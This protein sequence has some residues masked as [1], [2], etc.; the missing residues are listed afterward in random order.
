VD[1][2]GDVR[3]VLAEYVRR[4]GF[5]VIEAS[6]GEEAL[7]HVRGSRPDIVLLDISMPG[8]GGLETL[9]RIRATSSDTPVVMITANSDVRMAQHTLALGAV[10]YVPKPIDFGYLDG[11]LAAHAPGPFEAGPT[12]PWAPV[13]ETR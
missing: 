4:S 7:E 5:E 9:R 2:E 10:D 1:D 8:L 6:G 3:E 13:G 11:V 12:G